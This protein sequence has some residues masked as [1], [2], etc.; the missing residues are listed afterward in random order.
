[1]QWWGSEIASV[2]NDGDAKAARAAAAR[3]PVK[4]E[5]VLGKVL[6]W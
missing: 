5:E 6:E 3:N 1:M 4:T 2:S